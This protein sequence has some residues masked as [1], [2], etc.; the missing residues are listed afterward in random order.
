MTTG[1]RRYPEVDILMEPGQTDDAPQQG[2]ADTDAGR[3]VHVVPS[4]LK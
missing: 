1:A 2:L 4:L 3:G